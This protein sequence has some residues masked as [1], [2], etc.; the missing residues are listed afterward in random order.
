LRHYF[1][2]LRFMTGVM[3]GW[4]CVIIV[5]LMELEV[6]SRSKFVSFG[7]RADLRFMH[8][9]IDTYYK[10]NILIAMIVAHTFITDIIS[11]SLVPH[12]LNVVQVHLLLLV[13]KRDMCTELMGYDI[14]RQDPKNKYIPHKAFTY[15]LITTAWSVYCAFTQLFVIFIAFAQLD[16]LLFRLASDLL[17]NAVTLSFYLDG[18]EFDPAMY[19]RQSEHHRRCH[20]RELLEE[21]ATALCHHNA[22]HDALD[23]DEP[24]EGMAPEP[25][26]I[27]TMQKETRM[28]EMMN[29]EHDA[30]GGAR[31][32][33][34]MTAITAKSGRLMVSM[35]PTSSPCTSSGKEEKGRLLENRR[36]NDES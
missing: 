33:R 12:V 8:V 28:D 35:P 3:C 2:D 30:S 5:V 18:K 24:Q 19:T 29:E 26:R 21:D 34:C 17:A 32:A 15:Y 25:H 31:V 20:E 13:S 14:W 16:L 4:L 27:E 6:F 23:G 22:G 1:V 9:A 36:L 11:D 7:P 10:Y